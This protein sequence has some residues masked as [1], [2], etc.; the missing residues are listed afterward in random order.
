M[1]SRSDL[2]QEDVT[3]DRHVTVHH[4]ELLYGLEHVIHYAVYRRSG[5]TSIMVMLLFLTAEGLSSE[6]HLRSCYLL[7]RVLRRVL[8]AW[9][10]MLEIRIWNELQKAFGGPLKHQA[11]MSPALRFQVTHELGTTSIENS[12]TWV[13]G[14]WMPQTL[15][16]NLARYS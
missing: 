10:S 6:H 13:L 8:C 3:F 2:P 12:D 16:I 4:I 15:D 1:I 9:L 11:K 14:D 5:P 7:R